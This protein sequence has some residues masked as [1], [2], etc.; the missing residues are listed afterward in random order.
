MIAKFFGDS[1]QTDQFIQSFVS[2]PFLGKP[3]GCGFCSYS[4]LTGKTFSLSPGRQTE[5][6]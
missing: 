4:E 1:F 3:H 5:P 2:Q 6:V